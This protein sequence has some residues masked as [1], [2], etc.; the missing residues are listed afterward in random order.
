MGYELAPNMPVWDA[1]IYA[2]A[3]PDP[4]IVFTPEKYLQGFS[5]GLK[6]GKERQF[7][8]DLRTV[9]AFVEAVREERDGVQ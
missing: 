1:R 5:D 9:T 6:V 4:S 3:A 8:E 7:S 2:P